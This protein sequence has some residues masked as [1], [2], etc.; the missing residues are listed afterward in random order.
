MRLSEL[1]FG[2]AILSPIIPA[3][4][5]GADR[6]IV[7][8]FNIEAKGMK[9]SADVLD[10]LT[11][12]LGT[13]LAAQGYLVVPR[14]EL[15]KRLTE[16]KTATHRSCYDTSCQLE[17][18][19]ELAAEKSMGTQLIK[20]GTSCKLTLNLYD[21]KKA[22]SEL[23]AFESGGCD[24]DGIVK[25]LE[26][27]VLKIKSPN[28]NETAKLRG[29]DNK[30]EN[31][32]TSV[33]PKGSTPGIKTESEQSEKYY[34]PTYQKTLE[35]SWESVKKVVA[36]NLLNKDNRIF[37]LKRFLE[38]FPKNNPHDAQANSLIAWLTSLGEDEQIPFHVAQ[39]SRGWMGFVPGK[40]SRSDV[41][42]KLGNPSREFS[43]GGKLSDGLNY[44]DKQRISGT[45]E[46]NFYFDKNGTLFRIDVFPALAINRRKIEEIFGSGYQ[47][48]MTPK[49]YS[50]LLYSDRS[51]AI[52]F[53][54]DE[55]QVL[56]VSF[57]K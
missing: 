45:K 8:V 6:P 40:S 28:E 21:L 50:F 3:A 25:S 31:E 54:K 29:P 19:K 39:Q 24:E 35:Q 9:I 2:V 7:A 44:K 56:T 38:D 20:L 47:Q 11:D 43:G 52:F 12:Y 26:S 32:S 17:L 27:A 5:E 1:L 23:A 36:D 57:T 49:G 53:D 14:S 34:N 16:Q 46:S 37:A 18:G 33:P 15:K 51:I 4:T 42:A 41:L 48:R 13:Q 30:I 10:R 22:T 55:T